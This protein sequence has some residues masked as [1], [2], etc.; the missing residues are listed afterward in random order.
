MKKITNRGILMLLVLFAFASNIFADNKYGL[1]DNIQEGVILHCFDWKL[2]DIQAEI[3]NIAKAGFTAVQT[4]PLHQKEPL[5]SAWYMTYQPYDYIIGNSV[6]QSF[7]NGNVSTSTG[8]LTYR[9]ISANKLVY[10]GESHDTYAN[11]PGDGWSKYVD[12][13]YKGE[14][15]RHHT[16]RY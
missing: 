3:P 12:Q 2:S 10:W 6:T 7:S 14:P 8:N 9:G 11:D 1:K 13:N 5:N 4:S 15:R 16:A